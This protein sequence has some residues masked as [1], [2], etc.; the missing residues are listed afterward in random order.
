M[1]GR[2]HKGEMLL[3]ITMS[4]LQLISCDVAAVLPSVRHFGKSFPCQQLPH[5][6]GT[7][8]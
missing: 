5:I 8:V 3:E 6:Y 2:T 1:S 7:D 4:A